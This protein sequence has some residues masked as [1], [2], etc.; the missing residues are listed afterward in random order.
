MSIDT[1]SDLPPRVQY[2]ASAAQT[3]FP[4]PFPFFED[5]D[6]IVDRDGITAALNTDYTVAGEGD[7]LGGDVT[8]IGTAFAGGEIVTIYRDIAI[9]RDTDISQ[10]GQWLSSAYNDEQDKIFLILQQLKAQL[11]RSIR[12]PIIAEIDDVDLELVV[13]DFANKYLA[14]DAN[15]KPIP[16]VLVAGTI[17]DAIIASVLTRSTIG[18]LLYP[19]TLAEIAASV[20]PVNYYVPSHDADSGIV[21]VDRFGTNI[22]PGVTDMSGPITNAIAVAEVVA[23]GK[24][25]GAIVVFRPST[26]QCATALRH[27]NFVR[28]VGAGSNTTQ[29]SFS[30]AVTGKCWELKNSDGSYVFGSTIEELEIGVGNNATHGV[31]SPGAHQFSGLR[32]VYI[33]NFKQ[34][35]IEF[36]SLGGPARLDLDVWMTAANA[37]YPVATTLNAGKVTGNTVMTVPSTTGFYI[38]QRV[39]ILLDTGF[40]HRTSVSSFVANTSI[41][42]TDSLPSNAANGNAVR[43]SRVGA[44]INNGSINKIPEIDI[45]GGGASFPVDECIYQQNGHLIVDEFHTESSRDGIVCASAD[46][47]SAYTVQVE[48][49]TGNDTAETLFRVKSTFKGS[50]RVGLSVGGD[51]AANSNLIN[52]ITGESYAGAAGSVSNYEFS[53]PLGINAKPVLGFKRLAMRNSSTTN[54]DNIGHI[55]DASVTAANRAYSSVMM[56]DTN[57]GAPLRAAAIGFDFISGS[58]YNLVLGAGVAGAITEKFRCGTNFNTTTVPLKGPVYTVATLPPIGTVGA[59]CRAFVSDANATLTAGIGAIVVG[60]GANNV[61]VISDAANWRIG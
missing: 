47:D 27:G 25:Q 12:L 22:S 26:Y 24:R 1:V 56:R 13:A 32:R 29:V 28:C 35:G 9:E 55:V 5:S 7:D 37:A 48:C 17:T 8:W 40:F 19:R 18:L 42:I 41:T 10:N 3:L 2:V 60:G 44:I 54:W 11:A 52:E 46:A 15:G 39:S 36:G 45:E 50:V 4:A 58:T 34:V 31:Y 23:S 53:T 20:I 30:D 61:P 57:E 59:N 16:A 33:S 49:A 43:G 21:H 6:L 38:G 51:Q 14:F